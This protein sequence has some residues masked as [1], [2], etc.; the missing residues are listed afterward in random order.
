MPDDRLAGAHCAQKVLIMY[1]TVNLVK[2][3]RAFPFF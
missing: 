3:I 2:S 1:V